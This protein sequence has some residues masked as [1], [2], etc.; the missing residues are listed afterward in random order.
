MT[1]PPQTEHVQRP[2]EPVALPPPPGVVNIGRTSTGNPIE[3]PKLPAPS[4]AG[5]TAISRKPDP[6]PNTKERKR[7][8]LAEVD[9]VERRKVSGSQVGGAY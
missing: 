9:D 1:S 8:L 6:D 2:S 4:A 5:I 7:R 3:E